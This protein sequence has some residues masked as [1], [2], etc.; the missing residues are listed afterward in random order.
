[1]QRLFLFF[2]QFRAFIFFV[3]L[4]IASV[5]LIVKNN[6]Y[7]S[8]AFF[9]STNKYAAKAMSVSNAVVEFINLRKVN[10]DL[11]HENARLNYL[12]TQLQLRQA[13][14]ISK[15]HTL[16]PDVTGRFQFK[17]AKVI[18]N[19]TS[20]FNNYL[21]LDKGTADGIRPRMGVI[22]PEGVVGRVLYCSEHFSTVASILHLKMQFSIKFKKTG[23]I[24]SAK[25]SGY[26]AREIDLIDVPPHIN[27]QKGDTI[28]TSSYNPF[29]PEGI[30]VGTIQDFSQRSGS[31]GFYENVDVALSTD[32]YKLSYVYVVSNKLITEQDSLEH[33]TETAVVP[34]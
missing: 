22:S 25:W 19:S 29:Y 27:L 1:M 16:N 23:E 28:V 9:N 14:S 21:T 7:Q 32:F 8:A 15:A 34:D 12:Y 33:H 17:V 5:W 2:Y 13:D 18:N 31:S 11:A 6:R 24:G 4:E 26:N 20:K 30:M 3:L 10:E